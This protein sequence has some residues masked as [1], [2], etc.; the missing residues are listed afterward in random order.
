M[1]KIFATFIEK[2]NYEDSIFNDRN[3]CPDELQPFRKKH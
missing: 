3:D 2:T 1:G